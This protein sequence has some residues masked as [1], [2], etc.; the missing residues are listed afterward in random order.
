MK[1][2]K[3]SASILLFF[4]LTTFANA[5]V[6]SVRWTGDEDKNSDL[7]HILDVI[8]AKT[9]LR[10]AES[11]FYLMEERD[12]ARY[13][14]KTYFQTLAGIPIHQRTLRVWTKLNTRQV[15]QVEAHLEDQQDQP[16]WL[17]SFS[18]SSA[19]PLIESFRD[20]LTSQK[21]LA[22]VH[23]HINAQSQNT[24]DSQMKGV[25]WKD[26]WSGG[27][28]IRQVKAKGKRG[29]YEVHLS[30]PEG[31]I[32][33]SSYTEYPQSEFVSG[34]DEFSLPA[35]VF[36]IYEEVEGQNGQLKRIPT[37]LKYLKSK[38]ARAQEDPFAS[39]RTRRYLTDSYDPV[40][41]ETEAGRAK[42]YWAM[43]YIRR[44][45]ARI[46]SQVPLTDN[47]IEN[48]G[49]LLEGRYATVSI[50]PDAF[51]KFKGIQYNPQLSSQF[52]PEWLSTNEP[53]VDE[54]LPKA[55]F[56]GK[57]MDS[58]YGAW[59]RPARRLPNHDPASY[60]NDGF[61]EVQVYYAIN[62][63]F[64]SLRS[65]GFTD[66]DLSTRPFHAFL[67]N[68]DI[69]M[70]NNAFY[71]DDTINFTTYSAGAQN[72]ARDNSTIWHEL[73]HGLMDRL[74][75]DQI[76]LADTGGLSEGMADF[77]AQLVIEDVT[78]GKPFPGSE[79]FRIVNQ[80]GFNLT[81][82]VHDDGE[83]Y[84]GA[85]RDLLKAAL[86]EYGRKGLDE[87]TDLTLDAMRLT[88]NHPG[89][90][91][92]DWFEHMLFADQLENSK[93]RQKGKLRPL[94]LAA[95]AGRN[96]SM[97]GKSTASLVVKN[98]DQEVLST[99][100]GSRGAPIRTELKSNETATYPL[101][102]QVKNGEAYQFRFPVQIKVEFHPGALQGAVHWVDEEKGPLSFTLNT[103]E[104]LQSFQLS[105]TGQC[106]EVNREDG[107][108]VDYAYI[109]VWNQGET[110]KPVAKKRF[111]VR[112]VPK[113]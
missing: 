20:Q 7:R 99:G 50:H 94:I 107:S 62:T 64:D 110:Q 10:L 45:A 30:L 87:I 78:Q 98:G 19:L 77:L 92:K 59:F 84:G 63:L 67:F 86:K 2:L 74:M 106:D 70:K 31:R 104:E 23:T 38:I 80:T 14:F 3:R 15:V 32:L 111:Y 46:Q 69:S 96:F 37:Y 28:L 102:V 68:P 61:D 65:K 97:D 53:G 18:L 44:E 109:R 95:L 40:L 47:S 82:E 71:T 58:I 8:E 22:V 13:H 90:T 55:S 88:R 103:P 9:S 73:G 113:V 56:H 100:P 76:V 4:A 72:Y 34:A 57:P 54:M 79:D 6:H 105:V 5:Q 39:L 49:M 108:C 75:G 60:I 48:G 33:F 93:V 43:S 85:M 26:V 101:Q 81:N 1:I 12:L 25:Q 42:G 27:M 35:R 83:A 29:T 112:V 52:L 24:Q 41:G 36:P 11:D 91:A 21:T 16:L 51:Q 66:P 89:L 17:N